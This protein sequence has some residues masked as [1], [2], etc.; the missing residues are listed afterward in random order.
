MRHKRSSTPLF[1]HSVSQPKV[2][3]TS[4]FLGDLGRNLQIQQQRIFRCRLFIPLPHAQGGL[5][6]KPFRR[7]RFCSKSP[8]LLQK[9]TGCSS[10][11]WVPVSSSPGSS[12]RQTMGLRRCRRS[13]PAQEALPK[14]S[15]RYFA[16]HVCL[17]LHASTP[18]RV[19]LC[20]FGCQVFA[21]L[22]IM[23]WVACFPKTY[24]K[25]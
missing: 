1:N 6:Y 18:R 20:M 9:A 10:A 2:C 5:F 25:L 3:L 12:S 24:E 16:K 13:C 22:S 11:P 14:T 17:R 21:Q 7:I 15:S 23:H 19:H 4:P 8:E